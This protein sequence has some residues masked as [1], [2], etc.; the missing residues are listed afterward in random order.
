MPLRIDDAPDAHPLA[1]TDHVLVDQS[2]QDPTFGTGKVSVGKLR[3]NV[4]GTGVKYHLR[5]GDAYVVQPDYVYVVPGPFTID[6]GA[7]LMLNGPN[8]KLRVL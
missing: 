3:V 2:G 7:S 4:A 5:A 8:A 1:D 6:A